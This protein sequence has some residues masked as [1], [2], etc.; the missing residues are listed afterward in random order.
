MGSEY[1]SG[2]NLS[3]TQFILWY[4]DVE[5]CMIVIFPNGKKKQ[6]SFTY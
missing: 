6:Q 2:M 5:T 3:I 4:E 1:D